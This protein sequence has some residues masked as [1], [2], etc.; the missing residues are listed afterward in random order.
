MIAWI[1]FS[2]E[3][4]SVSNATLELGWEHCKICHHYAKLKYSG[5][6]TLTCHL[7]CLSLRIYTPHVDTYV[8]LTLQIPTIQD[9]PV[10]QPVPLE[11]WV[12]LWSPS[13]H[14]YLWVPWC[15]CVCVIW[16]N[17]IVSASWCNENPSVVFGVY[18]EEY[19]CG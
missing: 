10:T 4:I 19:N 5:H 15:V 13:S 16:T 2:F 7:F 9:A 14:H 1:I 3:N 11:P 8:A 6:W 17:T 18:V 12:C